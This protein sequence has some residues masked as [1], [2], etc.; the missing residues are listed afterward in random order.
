MH[1]NLFPSGKNYNLVKK[2][3]DFQV[4]VERHEYLC[5]FPNVYHFTS[6]N[7]ELNSHL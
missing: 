2:A 7:T 3:T 4:K 1:L 6:P 5:S